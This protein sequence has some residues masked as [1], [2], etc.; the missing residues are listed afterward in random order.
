MGERAR[1]PGDAT[2]LDPRRSGLDGLHPSS[3]YPVLAVIPGA[4]VYLN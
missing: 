3:L 1:R 4:R 2:P